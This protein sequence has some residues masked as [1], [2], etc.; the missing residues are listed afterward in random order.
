MEPDF[1]FSLET[2]SSYQRDALFLFIAETPLRGPLDYNI[3]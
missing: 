1:Y 2:L 3:T